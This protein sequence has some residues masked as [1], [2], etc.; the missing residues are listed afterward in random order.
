MVTTLFAKS[1]C[2]Q[3]TQKSSFYKTAERMASKRH[4]ILA[5]FYIYVVVTETSGTTTHKEDLGPKT[6]NTGPFEAYTDVASQRSYYEKSLQRFLKH[7][8]VMRS[9]V[10]CCNKQLVD[11]A[12]TASDDHDQHG[13][14]DENASFRANTAM[15]V[16][17]RTKR[18]TSESRECCHSSIKSLIDVSIN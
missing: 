9:E 3:N 14:H 10:V 16:K 8:K 1:V 15:G 5:V 4:I 6:G 11:D 12:V 2:C 18:K 13:S 17:N 7:V